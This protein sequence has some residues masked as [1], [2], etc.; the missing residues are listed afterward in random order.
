MNLLR[1]FKI[2]SFAKILDEGKML[3]EDEGDKGK[4]K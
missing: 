4:R 1:M 3:K 2:T